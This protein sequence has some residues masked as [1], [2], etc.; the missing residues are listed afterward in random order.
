[1]PP[2]QVSVDFMLPRGRNHLSQVYFYPPPHLPNL[3]TKPIAGLYQSIIEWNT[4]SRRW[5]FR[6]LSAEFRA[7]RMLKLGE[8]GPKLGPRPCPVIIGILT[9]GKRDPTEKRCRSAV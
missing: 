4:Y 9:S 3:P 6:S 2:K 8:V 1:M 7:G 5:F